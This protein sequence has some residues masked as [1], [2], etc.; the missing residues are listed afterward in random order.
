MRKEFEKIVGFTTENL[1]EAAQ[2]LEKVTRENVTPKERRLIM[3]GSLGYCETH[4]NLYRKTTTE[5]LKEGTGYGLIRCPVMDI[6]C[7]CDKPDPSHG[8]HV[9]E[10]DPCKEWE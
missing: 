7:K 5:S 2:T 1:K 8:I 3:E 4:G 6:V 9:S 10:V